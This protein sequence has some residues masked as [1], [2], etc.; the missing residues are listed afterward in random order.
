[1]GLI[2][3]YPECLNCEP[4]TANSH[5]SCALQKTIYGSSNPRTRAPK[6][7]S[8]GLLYFVVGPSP[9]RR[10]FFMNAA[11]SNARTVFALLCLIAMIAVSIGAILEIA[12]ARREAN[13]DGARSLVP[14][15]QLR[16]RLFS[17][18]IWLLSLGSMGS[19][20]M[21]LWPAKGD[22]E[23]G[24]KF[25]SV[26][27]GSMALLVIA[28]MLLAYDVWQISRRRRAREMSFEAQLAALADA[29]INRA[30]T[31]DSPPPEAPTP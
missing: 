22:A 14:P 3:F 10:T 27:S 28:L 20:V 16:L 15:S 21:W 4:E 29:E 31:H 30:Q 9:L 17:A 26:V 12:R 13:D 11:N 7:R 1:M 24:R 23:M 19:A 18:A 25:I 2:L 8:G 6:Y 5:R